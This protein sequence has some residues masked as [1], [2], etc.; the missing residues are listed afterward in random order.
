MNYSI[1][2]IDP[3]SD[4]RWDA[5]VEDHP[6]GWLCHLSGWK[7]VLDRSFRHMKAHY[8]VLLLGNEIHAALPVFEVRSWLTGN[9][10]VSIPFA[11]ICD[12]LVSSD[13]E[14]AQLVEAVIG[15]S[16]K[17]MIKSIEIR[18][19]ESWP[20]FGGSPLNV[21]GKYKHH[22]IPL[23]KSP[24]ELMKSFHRSCVRQRIS[25]AMNSGIEVSAGKTESDLRD[26]YRLHVLSRKRLCLPPQP[27]AFIKSLF[28]IFHP[29][30]RANLILGKKDGN[31]IAA[32]LLLRF[33]GRVSAE[34]A[35]YDDS[36]LN[37]SPIHL[38]F[39]EAIRTASE[40]GFKVFDFGRTLP[41]N[42][43][44]MDFK[45]RWGTVV[46]DMPQFHYPSSGA[47]AGDGGR[48]G[49][50][51][52]KLIRKVCRNTPDFALHHIGNFCYRHLG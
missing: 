48:E 40:D 17:R 45:D 52:Y 39:W 5:F 16:R 21:G 49:T 22:Y 25:R 2:T 9:R 32:L 23:K 27:Y 7:E 3:L 18:T 10:L 24:D 44:L 14:L 28:D 41:L 33:K 1:A 19:L 31:P 20:H 38:L 42:T 13:D 43:N 35:V 12:P 36:Y 29:D 30:G 51:G 34:Y 8:L 26:F 46:S 11:T 15:L 47:L 50:L 6:F 4:R 37:I